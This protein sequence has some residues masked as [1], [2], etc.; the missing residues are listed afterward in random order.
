[1]FTLNTHSAYTTHMPHGPYNFQF[2]YKQKLL[3]NSTPTIIIKIKTSK[4]LRVPLHLTDNF[5]EY[6]KRALADINETH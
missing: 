1:M 3:M 4:K 6:L 5:N 2:S